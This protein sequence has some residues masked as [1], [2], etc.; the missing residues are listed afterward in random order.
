[1]END[2]YKDLEIDGIEFLGATNGRG[3]F[4]ISWSSGQLGFGTLEVT[5]DLEGAILIDH[6][7]MS[8]EFCIALLTK[9]VEKYYV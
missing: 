1:M 3:A 5:K 2:K 7:S 6:E 8:K 4:F 9:L